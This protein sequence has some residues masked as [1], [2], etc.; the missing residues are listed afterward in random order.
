MD[1]PVVTVQ[2]G[3]WYEMYLFNKISYLCFHGDA[4]LSL[5]KVCVCNGREWGGVVENSQLH[6]GYL[7]PLQESA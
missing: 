1:A 5:S 3:R 2:I 7:V 6:R 4:T